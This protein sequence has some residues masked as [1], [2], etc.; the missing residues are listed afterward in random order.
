M[1]LK[2]QF[3][4]LKYQQDAITAAAD[5]FAGQQPKQSNFTVR[6]QDLALKGWKSK[7][8]IGNRLTINH[9]VILQNLQEVQQR[10]GI[11]PS[12][13]LGADPYPEFEIDMETGERVIIVTG[14]SNALAV[15]VSETFIENNSCIA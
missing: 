8:G 11:K 12:V 4:P 9:N 2:L 3:E 10:N 6:L 7:L 13:S 15:R 5:L 14:C 1:S